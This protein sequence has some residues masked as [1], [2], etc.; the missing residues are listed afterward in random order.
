ML[1]K[2]FHDVAMVTT[3]RCRSFKRISEEINNTLKSSPEY[4]RG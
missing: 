4:E 1:C 3:R 2:L